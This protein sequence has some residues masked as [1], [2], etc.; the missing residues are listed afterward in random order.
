LTFLTWCRI[1]T[2]FRSER[3]ILT[4]GNR[5]RFCRDYRILQRPAWPA[6]LGVPKHAQ[7]VGVIGADIAAGQRLAQAKSALGL[8]GYDWENWIR[9]EFKLSQSRVSKLIAIGAHSYF[10]DHSNLNDL[11]SLPRYEETVYQL[12]QLTPADLTE[13]IRTGAVHPELKLDEAKLIKDAYSVPE[14]HRRWLPP[15][16]LESTYH[17]ARDYAPELLRKAFSVARDAVKTALALMEAAESPMSLS[18]V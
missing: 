4:L 14:T 11:A 13:A 17:Y 8:T 10:Q 15:A 12:T 3:R 2:R 9:D 6:L 16:E 1:F 7:Q 5:C 18:L